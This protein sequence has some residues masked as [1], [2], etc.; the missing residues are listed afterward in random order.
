MI[1]TGDGG[2]GHVAIQRIRTGIRD[3][4][5]PPQQTLASEALLSTIDDAFCFQKIAHSDVL[6]ISK[7]RDSIAVAGGGVLQCSATFG[8]RPCTSLMC[9]LGTI[10]P[11]PPREVGGI[12]QGGAE[13]ALVTRVKSQA[14]FGGAE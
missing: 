13:F 5:Q 4:Q 14:R 1:G 9:V 3:I 12:V 6:G 11:G 8:Q 7:Y 2:V 10:E